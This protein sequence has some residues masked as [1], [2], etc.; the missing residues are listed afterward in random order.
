MNTQNG[1]QRPRCRPFSRT[2][3]G[4]ESPP[5]Q[6]SLAAAALTGPL[7]AC[8]RAGLRRLAF[9][10]LEAGGE[11]VELAD[12]MAAA[13]AQFPFEVAVMLGDNLYGRETPSA[14]VDRFERPY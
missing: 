3:G 4:E 8:L 12:K 11:E 7:A 5:A 9:G 14:Y 10:R 13:R 2:A 6:S 1:R